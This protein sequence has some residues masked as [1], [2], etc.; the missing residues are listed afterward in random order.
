MERFARSKLESVHDDAL[1]E[2]LVLE[3]VNRSDGIFLWV[4][5]VIKQLRQ[6]LEDGRD[7]SSFEQELGALPTELEE[8]FKHLLDSISKSHLRRAYQIFVMTHK[9]EGLG[10]KLSALSCL[11]LD[12]Y[13]VNTEFAMEDTFSFPRPDTDDL[14]N[15]YIW[16]NTQNDRARRLI[17]GYCKGLVEVRPDILPTQSPARSRHVV[18]V[19]RSIV[20]FLEHSSILQHSGILQVVEHPLSDFDAIGAI[21]QLHLAEYQSLPAGLIDLN[22][23]CQIYRGILHM[24]FH[25][26]MDRSQYH[27]L[28]RLESVIS[29]K[30]PGWLETEQ[31]QYCL[32]IYN[33]GPDP[34]TIET[35]LIGNL[36][37]PGK[38][39]LT[40][41]APLCISAWLGNI[42][43][44]Q[45]RLVGPY[46]RRTPSQAV[47]I[48]LHCLRYRLQDLEDA[49]DLESTVALFEEL[50]DDCRSPETRFLWPRLILDCVQSKHDRNPAR[51][52]IAGQLITLFL[53]KGAMVKLHTTEMEIYPCGNK[54]MSDPR[55]VQVWFRGTPMFKEAEVYDT[56]LRLLDFLRLS[57]RDQTYIPLEGLMRF[58]DI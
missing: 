34:C 32:P 45:W 8:L 6:A 30:F 12:A 14:H 23:W 39:E 10:T 24:R 31:S 54:S 42:S 29:R 56:P 22:H 58:C 2:R 27:F 13:Q 33:V 20:E 26:G 46:S 52:R 1:R 49:Q 38:T 40:L 17:Q 9:H 55:D 41:R 48:V 47:G 3:I 11:Y 37:S 4:V 51:F 5:L 7:I 43:Y 50:L 36:H 16:Y 21:S 44:V 19:H 57:M 15:L 35:T 25:V 28:E 53:R 18:F